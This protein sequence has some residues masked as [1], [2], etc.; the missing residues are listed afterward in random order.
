MT[1]EW[2]C[3]YLVYGYYR[4]HTFMA[5]FDSDK[6]AEAYRDQMNASEKSRDP[7]FTFCYI[8]VQPL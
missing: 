3:R 2:K 7:S 1:K 4:Y 5:K 6:D 8:E